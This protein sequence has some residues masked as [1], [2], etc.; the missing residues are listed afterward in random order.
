MALE[1]EAVEKTLGS[2][3]ADIVCREKAGSYVLIENQV[4]IGS[5]G[6]CFA[7]AGGSNRTAREGDVATICICG[8]AATR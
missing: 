2:F 1:F 4:A 5:S 6:D 8:F 7:G 3:W